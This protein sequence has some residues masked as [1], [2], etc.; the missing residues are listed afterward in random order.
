MNGQAIAL[1][2]CTFLAMV[3]AV[4]VGAAGRGETS[5]ARAKAACLDAVWPTIP[6]E[7]LIGSIDRDVRLVATGAKAAGVGQAAELST[8]VFFPHMIKQLRQDFHFDQMQ[9][10]NLTEVDFYDGVFSSWEAT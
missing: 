10:M 6:A 7:C 8:D 2:T 1:A 9:V 5:E 4:T 3:F